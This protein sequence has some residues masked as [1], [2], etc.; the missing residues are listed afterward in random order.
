MGKPPELEQ[1]GHTHPTTGTPGTK[2]PNTEDTDLEH[3]QLLLGGVLH[4]IAEDTPLAG[5]CSLDIWTTP[6]VIY[7][8]FV[9]SI[10]LGVKK[11][12]TFGTES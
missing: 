2:T 3:H 9:G 10:L 4:L 1:E 11:V 12:V 5:V 8:S 6:T 7:E